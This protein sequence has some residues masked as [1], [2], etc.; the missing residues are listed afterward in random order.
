M[1][2]SKNCINSEV[3][4]D[5]VENAAIPTLLQYFGEGQ[6]LFHHNNCFFHASRLTQSWFN[7]GGDQTLF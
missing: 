5:N 1:L 4:V 7:E 3:C 2:N 6:L